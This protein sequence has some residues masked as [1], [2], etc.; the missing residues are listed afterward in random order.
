MSVSDNTR[1]CCYECVASSDHAYG[2]NHAGAG[3]AKSDIS[4]VR[5]FNFHSARRSDLSRLGV[6]GTAG[7]YL[8]D[9]RPQN[10]PVEALL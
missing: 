1:D 2:D 8:E 3:P 6:A 10:Q 5:Q 7:A 9:E 4:L